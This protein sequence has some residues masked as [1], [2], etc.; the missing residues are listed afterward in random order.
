MTDVRDFF[1]SCFALCDAHGKGTIDADI[2]FDEPLS[3]HSTF[4]IGGPADAFA[5]PRSREALAALI[6]EA[7]LAGIPISVIGGGANLLVSDRGVRGILVGTELLRGASFDEPADRGTDGDCTLHASAGIPIAGLAEE[8]VHR[9]FSGLEFAAGLPGSVGGAVFMNARCY[10]QEMADSLE[11]IEYL[12]AS[13]LEPCRLELRRSEWSYKSTP[14]M[15]GGNLP[16]SII[17]GA[18][19]SLKHGDIAAMAERMRELKADRVKKGHF[20]WPSAGSMFKND[21]AFD[22]PTGAILDELGFRGRRHGDAMVSTKHAN[23][24]V[25]AGKASAEDMLALI[26]EA[27][28]AARNA[29]GFELE[30][31]V[32]MLGDWQ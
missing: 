19:L 30:P 32:V 16:G 4:K 28:D 2:R 20:D 6:R 29:F 31:E 3:A 26:D 27:R 5:L 22:R 17:T 9:G 12:D 21:R 24:F 13:T 14:F 10:G 15:P 25:N 11:S 18:V 1:A 7:R 8:A 23:I